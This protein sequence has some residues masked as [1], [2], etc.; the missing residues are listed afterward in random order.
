MSDVYERQCK[1]RF[2]EMENDLKN[3][4]LS[5]ARIEAK[6]FDGLSDDVKEIKDRVKVLFRLLWGLLSAIVLSTL[7][8]ILSRALGG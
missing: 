2:K 6:V 4:M 8:I 5:V 1:E 7:T 3:L